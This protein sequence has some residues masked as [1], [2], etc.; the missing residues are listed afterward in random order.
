MII[1]CKYHVDIGI[2]DF[3]HEYGYP[4]DLDLLDV[5]EGETDEAPVCRYCGAA[6]EVVIR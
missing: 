2:E 4:P 5:A 3:I 6:P 1:V